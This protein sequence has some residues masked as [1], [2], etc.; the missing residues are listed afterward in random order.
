MGFA[1]ARWFL[2][3]GLL[4]VVYTALYAFL[5]P[6]LCRGFS[7]ELCGDRLVCRSGFFVLRTTVTPLGAVRL[8]TV[9]ANPLERFF[10]AAALT[11]TTAGSRVVLRGLSRADA[12][13]W[14]GSLRGGADE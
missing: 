8:V 3:G 2:A 14:A 7:Y 13:A 12:E 4:A 11:V 10:G 1:S 9:S 5:L 6:R